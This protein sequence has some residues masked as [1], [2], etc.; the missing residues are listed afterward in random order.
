MKNKAHVPL[1]SHRQAY[2]ENYR[3][4]GDESMQEAG[5]LNGVFWEID[6]KLLAFPFHENEYPEGVA[7]SGNTYV[8][9]KLWNTVRPKGCN[10]PYNYYPRGRAV[11]RNGKR[12]VIYMSPQVDLTLLPEII[13]AFGLEEDPDFRIDNSRHYRCRL[14][15]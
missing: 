2:H 10:K 7:K 3:A 11:V 13:K 15:H 4:K 1:I 8:H 14:D 12:S 6:G 9:E 5:P